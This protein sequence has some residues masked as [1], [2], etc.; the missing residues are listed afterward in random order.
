MTTASRI[1]VT[2]TFL[3]SLVGCLMESDRSIEVTSVRHMSGLSGWSEPDNLGSAIN[4]AFNDQQ[5]AL[6]KDGLSLY[7]ASNRPGTPGPGP[8]DI[9]VSRRDCLDCEWSPPKN[10]G[11]PVNTAFNDASPALSRDGHWLFFLSNRPG[12]VLTDQSPP[13]PSSDIWVA[14]RKNVHDDFG[15]EEPVNLGAGVNTAGFEGGASHFENGEGPAQLYFNRNPLPA[16]VGGDIYVS[17]QGADGSFGMAVLVAELS[18]A[19]TDQRPSIAH[20]GLDIYFHSNRTG[21]LNGFDDIWVST[22]ES[23]L[24]PWL[25]P[26]NIGEPINTP[27]RESFPLI[28]SQ[29]G[30]EWLYFTRNVATPPATDLDLFVSTRT[31][32]EP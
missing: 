17:E 5:A 32:R 29:G 31:R 12:S 20:S 14:W 25:P 26:T 21:S 19:F 30:T 10:L 9:W 23:I 8:N 15:W 3:S 27:F 1:F 28:V 16:G 13:V 22:R 6:S 11:P 2:L 24:A 18:T 7:F 4:T